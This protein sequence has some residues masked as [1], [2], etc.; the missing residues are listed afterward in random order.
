MDIDTLMAL[1]YENLA[2]VV[3]PTH[4]PHPPQPSRPLVLNE[5]SRSR[6][7]L[8]FMHSPSQQ[9]KPEPSGGQS[10]SHFI[11][12]K[13][14]HT[15]GAGDRTT[16]PERDGVHFPAR[17]GKRDG[18]PGR[19]RPRSA[20]EKRRV[21]LCQTRRRGVGPR[22]R[23]RGW[24]LHRRD[25]TDVGALSS[26]PHSAALSWIAPYYSLISPAPHCCARACLFV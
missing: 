16:P 1:S 6:R 24:A 26:L 21:F 18:R 7:H 11:L 23:Y 12:C 22:A 4:P 3:A 19:A 2:A 5:A 9:Q 14:K 10:S 15:S 25:A 13:S 20:S 17:L 8:G